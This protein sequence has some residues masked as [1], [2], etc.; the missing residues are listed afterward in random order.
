M[1]GT[2]IIA[3]PIMS[4]N[5]TQYGV[6][7]QS[8]LLADANN[9]SLATNGYIQRWSGSAARNVTGLSMQ[10]PVVNGQTHLIVN[11]GTFDINLIHESTSS[12]AA[13]R[14]LNTN[15][16]DFVLSPNNQATIWYDSISNRWRVQK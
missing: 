5:T 6:S 7:T 9:Y 8:T 14:F 10:L 12:S 15:G 13:N 11:V 4:V 1:G 16:L 3:S 2:T